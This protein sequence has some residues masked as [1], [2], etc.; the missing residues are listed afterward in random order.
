MKVCKG[1][2]TIVAKSEDLTIFKKVGK[3]KFYNIS[4]LDFS[5]AY[6][7]PSKE[8]LLSLDMEC[9]LILAYGYPFK[10]SVYLPISKEQLIS[11]IQCRKALQGIPEEL[12]E[13]ILAKK[14]LNNSKLRI[15]INTADSTIKSV[16]LRKKK[17]ELTTEKVS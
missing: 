11:L 10:N 5:D 3:H 12:E 9:D 8:E 2:G 4:D 13:L 16:R 15:L 6:S 17:S 14:L 7:F 1:N